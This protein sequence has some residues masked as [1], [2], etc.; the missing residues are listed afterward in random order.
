MSYAT[1]TRA[2]SADE[3]STLS[4]AQLVEL[5]AAQTHTIASLQ[6]QLDWF[7]RQ[8]FGSKSERLIVLPD[9]RQLHL[10]EL[11][12]ALPVA[13]AP[14]KAVAAHT[15]RVGREDATGNADAES[16][17][18]FDESRV[19]IETITLP[20][21]EAEGLAADQFEVI[22]EKVS[23][24]LAQRPG[25]YV[26]LKYVRPLIKRRDTQT[27]HCP[28]APAGVL[29]GSRADVSFVAVSVGTQ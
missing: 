1:A 3:L 20:N 23:L 12:T 27:L 29:E 28:P 17:P 6:Q 9:A 18:F 22:G 8:L 11:I 10:G 2:P 16:L 24:R 5:V 26:V 19:P 4:A 7:K 14:R 25:C 13:P 21:P 15:R